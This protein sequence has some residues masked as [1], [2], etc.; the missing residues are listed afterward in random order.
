MTRHVQRTYT[1]ASLRHNREERVDA[2]QIVG[3]HAGDAHHGGA[4]VVALG[5]E[6]EL[7]DLRVGVPAS[8]CAKESASA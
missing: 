5:V 2:E 6:L 3:D 4:A 1:T 8:A 7:L